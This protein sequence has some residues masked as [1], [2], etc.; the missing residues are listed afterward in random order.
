[1]V[2]MTRDTRHRTARVNE[3]G[4]MTRQEL[5]V[6]TFVDIAE[7]LVTDFDGMEFLDTLAQR[8]VQLFDAAAAGFMLHDPQR[9]LRVVAATDERMLT[10]Q[11]L[12]LQATEG[13][14]LDAFTQRYP[15]HATM[16]SATG[17]WPR[18]APK[19]LAEGFGSV[20]AFPL[21]LQDEAIGAV[22]VS[23]AE[24]TPLSGSDV[25][26]AQ[27]LADVATIALLQERM[28]RRKTLLIEQLEHALD[29]RV[30]VEQAQGMIA[31]RAGIDVGAAFTLLRRHARN[32]NQR[33][34]AVAQDIV[35]GRV[36]VASVLRS[37]V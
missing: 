34:S 21:R 3:E 20:S 24:P 29:S 7:T 19:A 14:C 31:D 15:V 11:L 22:N 37:A 27:A 32:T 4:S 10:I 6:R 25:A 13:P 12:E 36:D 2:A 18:F 23:R 30:V 8:F 33:L 16:A 5:L 9:G 1:M 26:A 35:T 17:R 28:A